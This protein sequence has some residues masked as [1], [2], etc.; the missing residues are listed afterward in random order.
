MSHYAELVQQVKF[1]VIPMYSSIPIIIMF[2]QQYYYQL[3]SL[4]WNCYGIIWHSRYKD[5]KSIGLF[6]E[7]ILTCHSWKITGVN[8]IINDGWILFGSFI[9]RVLVCWHFDSLFNALSI[10]Q[11]LD[12]HA[13]N[14][15][16]LF[17]FIYL[18]LGIEQVK[19][20]NLLLDII[21]FRIMNS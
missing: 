2:E 6:T 10:Y 9:F 17:Y 7:D 20:N 8:D 1:E 4:L 12:F 19:K 13:K 15:N 16:S 18:F 5:R 3:G 11:N 21:L 14:K